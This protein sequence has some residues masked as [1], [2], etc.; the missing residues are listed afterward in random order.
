MRR[1]TGPAQVRLVLKFW[2]SCLVLVAGAVMLACGKTEAQAFESLVMPG[3]LIEAHA[4]VEPECK[5]CHTPFKKTEQNRLCLDCHK[6]VADDT[7]S[8]R[9]FHGIAPYAQN[10][11]CRTCHTDHK[12]RDARIAAF[13]EESFNHGHTDFPLAN[14]HTLIG[15]KSCH[16]ESARYRD[17]PGTCLACH[18]KDDKHKGT[19]GEKCESCHNDKTWK[20]AKFDHDKTRFALSGKHA[21]AKCETCHANAKYKD[22]PRVCSACHRKDDAHKGRY[23]E[24]CETCH[25]A[26]NWKSQFNHTRQTKYPLLGKH[27]A[28]KCDTC[29]T[30]QLYA[31]KMP[32]R[33]VSCHS[34]D[35]S[36]K[37][38]LG[39]RCETCHKETGWTNTS[40]EHNRDTRFPLF[41]KHK[42]AVCGACHK[43]G[44]KEKLPLDCL[45]CHRKDD[46]HKGQFGKAC[47]SCHGDKAWKPSTFD[48]AKA[49]K[50]VLR[51]AHSRIKCIA[52]HTG[53][54]YPREGG[55]TLPRGCFACHRK[56]DVHKGQLGGTCE[57]CHDERKWTGVRYDHNKSKFKLSGAHART[58]CKA[59]HRSAAFK[60][61][62]SICAKCHDGDDVHKRTLGGKCEICHS[63]RA[64]K[65]WDFD[66]A[67]QTS[68]PLDGAHTKVNCSACHRKTPGE[69][70]A[71]MPLPASSC[72]GC[73]SGE[74]IH[75]GGFGSTCERCHVTRDWRT[76]KP[77]ISRGKALPAPA[78]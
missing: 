56:D 51:E 4:K 30:K 38:T 75:S 50:F 17:A 40:F 27:A 43:N 33:C 76:L 70:G 21:D 74:D 31:E 78:K 60:D 5:K 26:D 69:L 39:D 1:L 63:T 68:Y 65:S 45:S 36:H 34:K 32:T 47:E 53:T 61:S 15:C 12:G 14:A 66:H 11:D 58:Q 8:R 72:F 16:K 19:L 3:K 35:D 29:H 77:G 20:E 73:H 6:P 37:G 23:G 62:P 49:T 2:K 48:H 25:N 59:C 24:K 28:A 64:W 71:V 9:G 44:L 67:K 42:A 55:A 22:T 54:L 18:K 57:S 52:C 13:D 41:N 46:S 7:A 10:K